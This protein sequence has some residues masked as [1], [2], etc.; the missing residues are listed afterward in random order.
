M[1]SRI[2]GWTVAVLALGVGLTGCNKATSSSYTP[3]PTKKVDPIQLKPGEEATIFP[4]AVG[5][6]WNYTSETAVQSARGS[7]TTKSELTF[8][9]KKIEETPNGKKVTI[10]IINDGQTRENQIWLINQKGIYQL[11]SGPN[12]VQFNPP[13]PVIVWPLN[14]GAKFNWSGTGKVPSGSG[15]QSKSTNTVRSPEEIDTDMG[16]MSALPIESRTDGT[17]VDPKTNKSTKV[18]SYNL[19][20]WVPKIGIVRYRQELATEGINAVQIL[21][22]KNYTLK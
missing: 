22:L 9:I 7:G 19:T 21:K 18:S 8:R 17:S 11:T 3:K 10:E 15:G 13:Q 4:V 6:T 20:W 1:I 14:P 12:A 16:R 2:Q 5:N